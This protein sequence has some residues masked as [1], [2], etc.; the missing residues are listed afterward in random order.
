MSVRSVCGVL[1]CALGCLAFTAVANAGSPPPVS[2]GVSSQQF[3]PGR[4]GVATGIEVRGRQADVRDRD[5][6]A[7]E[8]T[9]VAK[10]T[11]SSAPLP[12]Y[13][14][15]KSDAALLQ[16][17]TPFG[18]GTFWY[19]GGGVDCIYAPGSSPLCYRI[20]GAAAG[21]A[22]AAVNPAGIAQAVA[23]R[24]EL[25]AG[26][27]HASP[28]A[29]GVTGSDSWFWLD[30]APRPRELST[31]LG[32]EA[33]TVTAT[34]SVT[35]QFG[36]GSTIAGGAGVPYRPGTPPPEAIVHVF[37]TRCLPGD[38]G[39][40]PYVLPSCESE[41][42]RLRA[43]VTWQI[44]YTASGPVDAS[45]TLSARTTESSLAYPVSEVRGFLVGGGTQ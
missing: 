33:V 44:S 37:Q 17:P 14:T 5:A 43:L 16:D 9:I 34:P 27:L 32:G 3:G 38:R 41:G 24:L 12:T 18:P 31:S 21:G 39:R 2:I 13:P 29:E 6:E 22:G 36:D 23:E 7:V 35:W 25:S 11:T 1:V 4:A 20:T 28:M 8:V 26:E 19:G 30:P 45:G 40:N 10:Q 42:Y 15:L